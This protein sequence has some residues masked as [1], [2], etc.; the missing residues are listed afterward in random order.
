MSEDY[1]HP[2]KCFLS[3]DEANVLVPVKNDIVLYPVLSSMDWTTCF[4]S[5]KH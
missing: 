3:Q 2:L 5:V 4:P 1:F